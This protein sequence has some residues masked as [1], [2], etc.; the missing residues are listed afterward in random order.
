MPR[1]A[2]LPVALLTVGA[3][4]FC[5][6]PLPAQENAPPAGSEFTVV[7]RT[8]LAEPAVHHELT[9]AELRAL[10]GGEWAGW[11]R[12]I[13]NVVTEH[14]TTFVSSSRGEKSFWV[15]TVRVTLRYQ[16]ADIYVAA[17]YPPDSPTARALLGHER[18]HV[19]ADR[20]VAEEFAEKIRSAL[21][22]SSF[23]TYTRPLKVAS[24]AEGSAQVEAQLRRVIEPLVEELEKKRRS[25]SEA[26]DT[27]EKLTGTARETR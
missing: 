27:A 10:A 16:A 3:A 6:E 1:G 4:V 5:A 22:A 12:L 19:R 14:E 25:V 11:T 17:E 24:A 7:V 8:E 9:L 15:S 23:P 13:L 2:I 18:E 21:P 26:L 20:A